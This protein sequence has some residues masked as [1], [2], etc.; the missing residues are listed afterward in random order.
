[1]HWESF[2]ERDRWRHG[3]GQL[4]HPAALNAG[5]IAGPA[6]I[7]FTLLLIQSLASI[8]AFGSAISTLPVPS[9]AIAFRFFE[10][11][12]PPKP[13][14]PRASPA[15]WISAATRLTFSPAWPGHSTAGRCVV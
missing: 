8:N 13:P 12:T 11:N 3:T 5:F 7:G 2:A 15:S 9:T 4:A 14:C 1:M 6:L 10:P